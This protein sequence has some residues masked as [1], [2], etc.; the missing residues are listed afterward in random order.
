MRHPEEPRHRGPPSGPFAETPPLRLLRWDSSVGTPPVRL[1]RRRRGSTVDAQAA[2]RRAQWAAL[3][4][5]A[6]LGRA[7]P[8]RSGD[9]VWAGD[10]DCGPEM[11]YQRA[12]GELPHL[13]L[14]R[15]AQR[16]L[17]V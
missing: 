3:R 5:A 1:L 15:E 17:L 12:C 2:A 13:C 8:W 14:R 16:G 11:L 4:A 7:G 6:G 9:V 10:V